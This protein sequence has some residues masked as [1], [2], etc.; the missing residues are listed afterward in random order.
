V[1]VTALDGMLDVLDANGWLEGL[2]AAMTGYLPTVDHVAVATRALDLVRRRSPRAILLV[3]P[4]LGDDP[5]GLYVDVAAA[6][7]VREHL[8]PRATVVTPNRFELSW[9]TG[10]D[11]RSIADAA[12][13]A[14]QLTHCRVIATS[15][16]DGS[17]RIANI[18]LDPHE[19][20]ACRV[21]RLPK[22]PNGTGDLLSGLYIGH[23]LCGASRADTLGAAVAGVEQAIA[24]SRGASD[25][26]LVIER[27]GLDWT[28]ARPRAVDRL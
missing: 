18:D 23:R 5:R 19:P 17:D 8:V 11:V 14:E 7:A 2:D 16:P 28:A 21:E 12:L 26:H 22:V 6:A 15:V 3:D 27:G 24:A 25:L 4:V 1:D 13:A 9:L 10:L 20:L